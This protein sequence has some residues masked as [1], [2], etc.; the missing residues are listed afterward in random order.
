VE[1]MFLIPV[2]LLE[3]ICKWDYIDLTLLLDDHY[4]N[5][6]EDYLTLGNSQIV[7]IEPYRAQRCHKQISDIFTW[8]KAFSHYVA[9]P[10]F[11]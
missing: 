10:N 8:L 9:A 7:V 4:S 3:N 2:K 11:K 5:P 6:P 1:G